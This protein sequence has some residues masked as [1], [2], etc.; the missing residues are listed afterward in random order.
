MASNTG[1]LQPRGMKF[2]ILLE[3]GNSCGPEPAVG[4]FPS[5]RVLGCQVCQGEGRGANEEKFSCLFLLG[6]GWDEGMEPLLSPEGDTRGMGQGQGKER[7]GR[8]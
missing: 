6:S 2:Q 5:P 8:G 7:L 4:R 1:N 3:E